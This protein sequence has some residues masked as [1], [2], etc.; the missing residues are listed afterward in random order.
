MKF[1]KLCLE[2]LKWR[3]EIPKN[4]TLWVY[5]DEL[6]KLISINEIEFNEQYLWNDE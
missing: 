3:F 4:E 1:Q 6:L 2:N 5:K